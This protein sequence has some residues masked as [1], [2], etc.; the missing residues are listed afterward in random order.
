[1]PYLQRKY[2]GRSLWNRPLPDE[3]VR[4]QTRSNHAEG[5][6]VPVIRATAE[7]GDVAECVRT[8]RMPFDRKI[9]NDLW[10]CQSHPTDRWTLSF[11]MS[12]RNR[13]YTG[14]A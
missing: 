9:T 10:V 5:R 1:V 12:L 6:L 3:T 2:G 13:R 11:I 7:N 14:G 4:N 8:R